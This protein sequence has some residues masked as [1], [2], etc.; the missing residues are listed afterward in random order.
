M[1]PTLLGIPAIRTE[2]GFSGE[3]RGAG[4]GVDVD[5]QTVAHAVKLDGLSHRGVDYA[6]VP[7]DGRA[8]AAYVLQL[9]ERPDLQGGL[10][11]GAKSGEHQA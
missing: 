9:V 2:D 6:R 11:T 8:M 4:Q 5:H 1:K 10:K 3:G 7:K